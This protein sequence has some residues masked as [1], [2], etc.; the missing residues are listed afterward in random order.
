M[1]APICSCTVA[2]QVHQ[3]GVAGVE[4]QA[5]SKVPICASRGTVTAVGIVKVTVCAAPV[6]VVSARAPDDRSSSAS[7]TS[8]KTMP[9]P[10][11]ALNRLEGVIAVLSG[12]IGY[13]HSASAVA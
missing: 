8:M 4:A 11:R 10:L 9:S 2:E 6:Q 3:F 12:D 1:P 5:V 7:P 13:R